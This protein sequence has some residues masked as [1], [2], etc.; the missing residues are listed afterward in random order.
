MLGLEGMAMACKK[1]FYFTIDA[2]IAAALLIT[3]L[4][5]GGALYVRESRT[6]ALEHYSQDLLGILSSVKLYEVNS[7]FVSSLSASGVITDLN[8]TILEQAGEFWAED[9]LSM[10]LQLLNL[11]AGI[12]PAQFKYGIFF[13]NE[14]VYG[15]DELPST[16]LVSSKRLISG[17]AKGKPVKGFSSRA[18]LTG[19]QARSG[20]SYA[21]FGGFVGEGNLTLRF[22]L[23]DVLVDVTSAYLEL[24]ANADFSLYV[25]D[26]FSGTYAKGSAGGGFMSADKWQINDSYLGNFVAGVNYVNLTFNA[27]RGYIGGGFLRVNYITSELN[28]SAVQFFTGTASQRHYFPGIYGMI[29][30]YDSFFVP[31]NIS[32]MSAHLHYQSDFNTFLTIGNVTVFSLSAP[33]EQIVD[34]SNDNLA[35]KLNYAYLSS[36]TVP[37]RL[38]S[39]TG[40]ATTIGIGVAD[41]VLANDLS[42]SMEFCAKNPCSTAVQGPERYC[43]TSG[44]YRPETGTYCNWTTENFTLPD[45]GAVCSA[46]WHALC[47]VN[48][49]RKIDI[50]I[51]ASKKF[52]SVLLGT[53]GNKM[54]MVSYTN[55]WDSVVPAGG[56]WTD[57][58]APFPDSI[59]SYLNL[60]G[61]ATEVSSHVD[62][63]LDTYWGTCICCGVTKAT[64]IISSMSNP[65]RYKSIVIMSD[66]EA[67]DKC[68]GVGTGNAKTDAIEAARR[69]CDE[70][71]ISVN[72][73]GF[74]TDVDAATL[75]AMACNN[76]TYYNATSVDDLISV[77]THIAN[78]INQVSYYEQVVN[79]T[80]G[81]TAAGVLYGDSYLEYNYTPNVV[82]DPGVIPAVLETPRFG[83]NIS[84]ATLNLLAGMKLNDV[85]VTSYSGNKWTDNLTVTNSVAN[86]QAFKLQQFSDDYLVIGDPFVVY[87]RPDLFEAG[88]N[89]VRIST[90]TSP[91]N[92]TGGSVDDKI[93]YTLLIPNFVSHGGVF[94]KADGC[95]WQIQFEDGTNATFALPGSYSGTEQCSFSPKSYSPNDAVDDSIYR[96]LTLLDFDNDGLL[97]AKFSA[98]E[99]DVNLLTLSS[100]PFLWGP[101]IAEVRVWQ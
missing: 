40:N 7:S 32:S 91:G 28:D 30:L 39:A 73:V 35:S 15:P 51:N 36:K 81:S 26:G 42:G 23:P 29:N 80:G 67:T 31:G 72:T 68:I 97:D 44:N 89:L 66:G 57:R 78:M 4:T 24:D 8:N 53:L 22:V 41:V 92:Y 27:T 38:G 99:L 76:G 37:L 69:A 58:F 75:Q 25:N 61:N 83:N 87:A 59:V 34:L 70:Y 82:S 96:L 20:S 56:S 55:P 11:T 5:M 17:L 64:E 6:A 79:F 47:P 90:A 14:L 60:T 13:G 100:V 71:N 48:D 74:G 84:Q 19:F 45:D 88:D 85:R 54:G 63:Y 52:S 46:R 98:G 65:N 18:V 9:N 50:A 10:A 3:G 93:I 12:L 43:G 33:G 101:T 86:R 2:M 95:V 21:Y 62:K 16:S 77:Y 49:T 94:S 1:G